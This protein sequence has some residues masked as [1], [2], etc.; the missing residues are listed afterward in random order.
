MGGGGEIIWLRFVHLLYTYVVLKE[1]RWKYSQKYAIL[2]SKTLLQVMYLRRGGGAF[3]SEIYYLNQNYKLQVMQ[4]YSK[5]FAIL[6]STMSANV[7]TQE[8]DHGCYHHLLIYAIKPNFRRYRSNTNKFN[9][10]STSY[11]CYFVSEV[12][13][14]IVSHQVSGNWSVTFHN[15]H[16]QSPEHSNNVKKWEIRFT[17]GLIATKNK[18][19]IEKKLHVNVVRN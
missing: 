18:H 8:G 7:A 5:V 10:K 16:L 15:I 2:Q 6:G 14:Q 13:K 11:C 19:H 9:W 17:S 4:T 1:V 3:N 12:R